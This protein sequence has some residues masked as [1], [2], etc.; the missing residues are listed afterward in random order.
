MRW[1]LLSTPEASSMPRVGVCDPHSNVILRSG[2]RPFRFPSGIFP[3]SGVCRQ[4]GQMTYSP[5]TC[6][7][8]G[9]P[10]IILQPVGPPAIVAAVLAAR[11]RAK[12]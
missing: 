5:E 11:Q 4:G 1:R 9:A 2:R 7:R 3:A 6:E 8:P 12:R 10:C